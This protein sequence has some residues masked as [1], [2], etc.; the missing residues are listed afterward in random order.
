MNAQL[1]HIDPTDKELIFEAMTIVSGSSMMLPTKDHLRA[2]LGE[3][4]N[5]VA[6]LC[7]ACDGLDDATES[8]TGYAQSMTRAILADTKAALQE[9]DF[10]GKDWVERVLRG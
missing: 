4:T 2:L 5:H 1:Q 9:S 8:L 6:A 7:V 10:L 3:R